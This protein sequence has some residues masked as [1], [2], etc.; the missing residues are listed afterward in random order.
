[1]R[2]VLAP[3]HERSLQVFGPDSLGLAESS[4]ELAIAEEGL[5][6]LDIAAA[7]LQEAVAIHRRVVGGGHYRTQWD[8]LCLARVS[9]AQGKDDE[10]VKCCRAIIA[11]G[12]GSFPGKG[13]KGDPKGLLDALHGRGDPGEGSGLLGTLRNNLWPAWPDDWFRGHIEGM[14]GEFWYR[15][16]QA[17]EK[18]EQLRPVA[19]AMMQ[20]AVTAMASNPSTPPRFLAAARDRLVRVGLAAPPQPGR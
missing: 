7:L 6:H 19:D 4:V 2:E 17:S 3:E 10:M 11:E 15:L 9:L 20:H 8:L 1:M 5:R 14:C 13:F 16:A 12:S 18:P